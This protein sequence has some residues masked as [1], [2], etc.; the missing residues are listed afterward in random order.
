MKKQITEEELAKILKEA[1]YGK[2]DCTAQQWKDCTCEAK[3]EEI[4]DRAHA[5]QHLMQD[6]WSLGEGNDALQE[7][8][9]ELESKVEAVQSEIERA[10]KRNLATIYDRDQLTKRN[11][12][13]ETALKKGIQLI[14]ENNDT[15]ADVNLPAKLKSMGKLLKWAE[16]VG[17]ALPTEDKEEVCECGNEGS[18][19]GKCVVCRKRKRTTE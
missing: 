5:E 3:D 14:H 17:G 2:E 16:E 19:D 12:E 18:I 15:R 4:A 8:N 7:R 13:L 9:V 6:I 10:L 11:K 1:G